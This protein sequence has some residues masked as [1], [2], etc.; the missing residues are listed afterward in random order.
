MRQPAEGIRSNFARW[1]AELRTA[2]DAQ[3]ENGLARI[4][5]HLSRHLHEEEPQKS[6]DSEQEAES[7]LVTANAWAAIASHAMA[8]I[9]APMSPFPRK[10]AGWS[11]D[12]GDQLQRIVRIL[13]RH[14]QAA[15]SYLRPLWGILS[16]SIGVSFPWAGV[17]ISL[18][19]L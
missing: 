7:V 4:L 2:E 13:H 5:E 9:Y 11:Q 3:A 15:V 18:E 17:Q 10:L 19:F 12:V 8:E 14:V 1:S 16:F 6:F